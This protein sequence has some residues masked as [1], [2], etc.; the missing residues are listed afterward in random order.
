MD[1]TP[2][3]PGDL[4]G[5][6]SA[7]TIVN[8]PFALALADPNEA[9]CPL[10]YVNEAFAEMTGY[11]MEDCL[12]RNCRFLQGKRTA[13][14]DRAALRRAI[15]AGEPTTIDIH[16]YRQDGTLFLNRLMLSP[17]RRDDGEVAYYVGISSDIT[18]NPD[19]N[20]E[21]R[22][23]RERL[24]ELQHRVKNHLSMIISMLRVEARRRSHDEV[25][26]LL[27][28]R[29][30]ALSLLYDAFSRHG[31]GAE[32]DVPVGAYLSRVVSSL[33]MLDGR[34]GV[35]IATE[36]DE[37]DLEM[38]DAARL[39]LFLSE[40]VTNALQHGLAGRDTGELR[41]RFQRKD[42]RARLVV[43]D[44]GVGM[45]DGAWPGETSVGSRIV[46]DLVARLDGDL[47]VRSG[48]D[49]TEVTLTFRRALP[50]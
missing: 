31:D 48:P 35:R 43:T 45:P 41:V 38:D 6:I 26:K 2:D 24:R 1:D 19:V 50:D 4:P 3:P 14:E 46:R 12:G 16:N 17:L 7:E 5:G 21:A 18:D 47:S 37:V 42:G 22:E 13:P 39:G 30:E 32:L 36:M 49:G 25:I 33:H 10:V 40:V 28:R 9:D 29:V 44:D 15:D 27:T 20:R 11:E 34:P 23:L 8:L